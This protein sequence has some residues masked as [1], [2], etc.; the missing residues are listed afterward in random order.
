MSVSRYAKR[1][2]APLLELMAAGERAR[3]MPR[4]SFPHSLAA[5]HWQQQESGGGY[6]AYDDGLRFIYTVPAAVC[7]DGIAPAGVLLAVMDDTTSWA[8]IGA[9]AS[10]RP[11]VSV[12]LA[13]EVCDAAPV[14]ACER[15]VFTSRVQKL[16]RSMGF[17]A[18]EIAREATGE[19]VALGRHTKF[20]DMGP[21]W[22][23]AFGRA[24]PLTRA[25]S[26]LLLRPEPPGRPDGVPSGPDLRLGAPSAC[27]GASRAFAVGCEE[28][29][30]NG[31]PKGLGQGV[32]GGCQAMVHE[33][34]AAHVVAQMQRE[35]GEGG[36]R[37]LRSIEV[38]Y[39]SSAP[40]GPL[41]CVVSATRGERG[42]SGVRLSSLLRPTDGGDATRSEAH[43]L[44]SE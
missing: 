24:Y 3:F 2:L 22:A 5:K 26:G 32:H 30:L 31:M 44:F 8:A 20:L 16:G 9:D 4:W 35:R 34:A 19:Q 7:T 1:P 15:L 33:A 14:E 12:S 36:S 41:A 38:T 43:M 18:C 25:A 27:D 37:R 17:I 13:L 28:H 29:H 42:G 39:L 21:L 23:F 11:G 10:R 40:P 6:V